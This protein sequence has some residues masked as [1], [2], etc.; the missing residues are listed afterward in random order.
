ML[1]GEG[2]GYERARRVGRAESS[3]LEGDVEM[4]AVSRTRLTMSG[5]LSGGP[6]WA[7]RARP[8][9]KPTSEGTW[10]QRR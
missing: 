2:S 8:T 3:V 4:R 1:R 10:E 5:M 7:S 6:A 9:A